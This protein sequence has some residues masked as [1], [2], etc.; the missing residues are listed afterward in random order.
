[1]NKIIEYLATL[2]PEQIQKLVDNLPRLYAEIKEG[3]AHG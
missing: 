1:M 3:V 2:T